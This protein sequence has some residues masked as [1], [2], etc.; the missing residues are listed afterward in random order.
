MIIGNRSSFYGNGSISQYIIPTKKSVGPFSGSFTPNLVYYLFLNNDVSNNVVYDY[1][2]ETYGLSMYGAYPGTYTTSE[3][4]GQLGA[5]TQNLITSATDASFSSAYL[6]TTTSDVNGSYDVV[7]GVPKYYTGSLLYSN[8]PITIPSLSVGFTFSCWFKGNH[9][10]GGDPVNII[11]FVSDHASMQGGGG[12]YMS[13]YFKPSTQGYIV[14]TYGKTG[15]SGSQHDAIFPSMGNLGDNKWHFMA[16]RIQGTQF[17]VNVDGTWIKQSN[18]T[19][20]DSLLPQNQ[21]LYFTS[22]FNYGN[23]YGQY[24]TK[25]LSKVFGWSGALTDASVNSLLS[26]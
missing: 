13:F 8:T 4:A 16:V 5:D 18:A 23:W 6:Y 25:Y 7:L 14:F 21:Q 19:T 2:T 11:S 26:I 12:N 15:I 22:G 9:A 1:V 17:D 10:N 24:S 20:F 3:N